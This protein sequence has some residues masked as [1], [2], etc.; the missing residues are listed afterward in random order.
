MTHRL[1]CQAIQA[2]LCG[3][4]ETFLPS[5]WLGRAL[6]W[7][8]MEGW[9]FPLLVNR[10]R[11]K[12]IKDL[13]KHFFSTVILYFFRICYKYQISLWWKKVED[14]GDIVHFPSDINGVS[15]PIYSLFLLKYRDSLMECSGR[16]SPFPHT[17]K[18]LHNHLIC[19][20]TC[21]SFLL[22]QF[23]FCGCITGSWEW[24][25]LEIV[26]PSVILLQKQRWRIRKLSA[27]LLNELERVKKGLQKIFQDHYCK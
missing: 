7:V 16:V 4:I 8:I 3:R 26:S 21:I 12:A 14:L 5:R 15:L 20:S 10:G 17:H 19:V 1:W 6:K 24:N 13:K 27:E 22:I 18:A 2:S 23:L 9:I 11:E 25:P